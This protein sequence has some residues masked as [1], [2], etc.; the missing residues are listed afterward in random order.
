M[1]HRYAAT[2]EELVQLL[3]ENPGESPSLF[4]RDDSFAAHCYDHCSASELKSAFHRD[5]DPEQ[6]RRWGISTIEWKE[7][8]ALAYAALVARNA[9]R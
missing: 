7:S 2:A 4:L 1:P 3:T 5:P 8:V 9:G 6:C